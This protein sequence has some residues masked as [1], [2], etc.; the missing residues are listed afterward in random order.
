MTAMRWAL[1]PADER[2]PVRV[3][4]EEAPAR[5]ALRWMPGRVVKALDEDALAT[6]HRE[7]VR[8]LSAGRRA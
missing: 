3:F 5:A 7:H 8:S 4:T 2:M 1:V 6:R